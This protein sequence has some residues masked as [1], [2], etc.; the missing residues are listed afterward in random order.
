MGLV[1]GRGC[2]YILLKLMLDPVNIRSAAET[3]WNETFSPGS[4]DETTLG[5]APNR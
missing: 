1:P 2:M 4:F 5:L 3:Q